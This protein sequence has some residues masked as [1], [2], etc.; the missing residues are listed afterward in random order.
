V[1]ATPKNVGSGIEFDNKEDMEMLDNFDVDASS[2]KGAM[3]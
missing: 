1:A 2:Q 3:P